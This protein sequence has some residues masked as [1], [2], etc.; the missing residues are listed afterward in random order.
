MQRYELDAW[1]GDHDLTDDQLRDLL[2]A[3]NEIEERYPEPDDSEERDAALVTA[4]RLMIADPE[5][6]VDDLGADLLRARQAEAAALAGIRHAATALVRIDRSARGIESQAGF[7][8]RVG[9]DR[10]TVRDWIGL[11]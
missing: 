3:A 9:V 6:V 8:E 4:Y 1:L 7:A 2:D 11:R 10:M 5:T